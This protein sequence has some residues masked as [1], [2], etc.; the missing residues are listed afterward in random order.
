MATGVRGLSESPRPP[1]C[2]GGL[3]GFFEG[4]ISI[5]IP[6][7]NE[8]GRIR[9]LLQNLAGLRLRGHEVIV[10]DGGSEDATVELAQGLADAV[11]SAPRGRA[12]QM[13]AGAAHAQ[14]DALLFL[15]AD[16]QLPKDADWL[17]L[18]GLAESRLAWGRFDVKI[19]GSHAGLSVIAWF[20]NRRSRLTGICTGDQGLFVGRQDFFAIGGFPNIALMEDIAISKLLKKRSR[21]L[22]LANP[23]TTSGRRWEQHGILR[24]IFK[25]WALRL[26][27][28]F[29]ANPKRLAQIYGY[30]PLDAETVA[31]AVF[32]RAPVPGHAKTRLIPALGAEGAA[33]LQEAFILRSLQTALAAGLGPVSL[34]CTPDVSH[35]VFQHCLTVFGATAFSQCE[36]DLGGRMLDTFQRLCPQGPVLLI[37]TDCPAL[38][39]AHL[40]AA[41]QSLREGEDAV[42]FP[43]EDGGY[44]LVGVRQAQPSLFQGIAWGGPEVMDATRKR[45]KQAG[46]RWCEPAVLWDVDNPCDLERLKASGLMDV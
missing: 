38:T 30:R 34:W 32:A 5:I 46:L 1:F 45:L 10:A 11:V 28:F 6:T 24:T 44:V 21:P 13:N 22:C 14:G 25:M 16:T 18:Q 15:H 19:E 42:F 33:Q 23:V 9:Q 2:K 8:V 37:G 43:A 3:N 7:L 27:F 36:G 12:S 40:R 29:G 17:I 35:S 31:I 26:A 4:R 41:A 39:P 20:M